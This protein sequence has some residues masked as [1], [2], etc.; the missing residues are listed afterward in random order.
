MRPSGLRFALVATVFLTIVST[1]FAWPA[2]TR[3]DDGAMLVVVVHKGNPAKAL[4]REDLRPLFQT[5][6]TE[7]PDG[8]HAVPVNLPEDHPLRQA[9]DAAILG[10]DP[11][12]VERYWIDRKI[13]GGE[14]PP[15]K[16]STPSAALRVVASDRGGVAYMAASDVN[17]TVRVVAR[18]S[19][20]EVLPP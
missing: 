20:G 2:S 9:F 5:N 4:T 13:R 17:D 19:K 16:V 8:T 6:R 15:H 3:A 18:I 12:R 1:V 14:R 11:D 7:W 10:L